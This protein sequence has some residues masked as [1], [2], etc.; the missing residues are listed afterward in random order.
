M[1]VK[2]WLS[3]QLK[4]LNSVRTCAIDREASIVVYTWSGTVINIYLI[5]EPIK[6]RAI[7]RL[8]QDNTRVGVGTLFSVSVDRVPDD[9]AKVLPDESLL[10]L[11]GKIVVLQ[12]DDVLYRAMIAL[13]FALGLWMIVTYPRFWGIGQGQ[14]RCWSCA[15]DSS[16]NVSA[17][18]MGFC[19]VGAGWTIRSKKTLPQR[20]TTS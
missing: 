12:T 8:V 19:A 3:E 16:I 7:K 13:D 11:P 9:G 1:S 18:L 17:D 15:T 4:G 6:P 20:A 10:M 5:N 14:S 2:H